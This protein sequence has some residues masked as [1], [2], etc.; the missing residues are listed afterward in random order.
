MRQRQVYGA[1][2]RGDWAIILAMVLFALLSAA[3]CAVLLL[4]PPSG[5]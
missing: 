4:S 1:T 5:L 3:S 2:R